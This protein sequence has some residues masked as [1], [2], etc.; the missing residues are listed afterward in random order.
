MGGENEGA[1]IYLSGGQQQL[2][3]MYGAEMEG[4]IQGCF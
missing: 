1:G 2:W 4:L 3:K